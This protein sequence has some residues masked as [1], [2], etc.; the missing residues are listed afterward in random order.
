[1]PRGILIFVFVHNIAEM[2]V[3]EPD[4]KHLQ[5]SKK[6][7]QLTLNI[8]A[9]GFSENLE[10]P[11]NSQIFLHQILDRGRYSKI[12]RKYGQSILYEIV[13]RDG[14]YIWQVRWISIASAASTRVIKYIFPPT[15]Q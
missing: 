10:N 14:A 8:F 5:F 9:C 1:M 13:L 6:S 15:V 2:N 12:V 11:R 3:S 4:K 7:D